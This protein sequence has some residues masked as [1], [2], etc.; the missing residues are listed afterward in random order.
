VI[1]LLVNVVLPVFLVIGG[2][3]AAARAGVFSAGVVDGLMAFTLNFAVPCL[4]FR[5]IAELDL[6][7]TFDWRLLVSFYAGAVICFALGIAGARLIFRRRPGEAVAIG[8][9]ALFSNSLLLGIPIM[10]RA[11]GPDALAPN[12]AII[13]IHAPFCYLLG[14]TVMEFVRAD[15]RGLAGTA[16]AVA[17][18]MFRNAL[19]IGLALGFVVNLAG[20][21]LPEPVR[22]AVGMMADAALPAALFGLG[23]VLTRYAIRASLGE[24]GLIAGLSLV[25]H[26]AVAYGLSAHVFALPEGFVRSAVVTAAMAPGV[27]AY[28]FASLYARGQAQAASVVLLATAASVFTIAAWLALLGA[29]G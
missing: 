4:L 28:V 24:A 3:Y 9:G 6:G 20:V 16:R 17:R 13:A 10:E 5:G 23:G 19:M 26:P 11:Y 1:L 15:G 22:V 8:F 2:G 18:A 27:N 21:A 12:F 14:I 29:G 25:L 7:A